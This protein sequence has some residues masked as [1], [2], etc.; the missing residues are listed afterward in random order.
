MFSTRNP[1]IDF[2]DFLMK[3][4][5]RKDVDLRTKRGFLSPTMNT[6]Q[7]GILEKNQWAGEERLLKNKEVPLDYSI[8]ART[9]VKAFVIS[10]KDAQ[11]KFSKELM[12]FIEKEMVKTFPLGIVKDWQA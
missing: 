6:Y 3:K 10:K 9:T 2:E 12:E 7:F 11:K 8:V 4:K 5:S 1:L